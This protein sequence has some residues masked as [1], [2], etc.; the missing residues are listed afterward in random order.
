MFDF[1]HVSIVWAMHNLKNAAKIRATLIQNTVFRAN[2]IKVKKS[3]GL[4][5]IV[6]E[7]HTNNY[8]SK[9]GKR[10]LAIIF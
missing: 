4:F 3:S 7:N 8:S 1:E 2:S 6:F 10:V 5:V 9:G